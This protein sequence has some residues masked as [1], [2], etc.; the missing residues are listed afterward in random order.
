MPVK[1]GLL[2][3][4]LILGSH[5]AQA[6]QV[7]DTLQNYF[8]LEIYAGEA[9][10]VFI[11]HPRYHGHFRRDTCSTE[12]HGT[13]FLSINSGCWK[14]I[15]NNFS[16]R[17]WAIGGPAP[18]FLIGPTVTSE[19]DAINSAAFA[20]FLMG[21]DTIE[22]DSL[23]LIDRSI[24]LLT[25]NT[26]LG[27][28]DN[29]G[30]KRIN[31]PVTILTDTA[32][33]DDNSISVAD[34]TGFKKRHKIN[35]A[36]SIDFDSL[37]GFVAYT[38]SINLFLGGDTTIFLSG[39]RIQKQML[40]GDSVSLFFPMM[41]AR[42]TPVDSIRIENMVFNG[43]REKYNLNYDWRVSPTL[44]I[45]T[46][47]ATIISNCRFEQIPNEN[48]FLC[49]ATFEHCSGTDLN[50]SALHFSCSDFDRFTNVLY[51]NFTNTNQ[52]GNEIMQHSEAALTFSAKVQN[53]RVA[54]NRF[55]NIE[56]YGVGIF[57]NDD[58]TNEITDN[59]FDAP[60]GTIEFDPFYL[61]PETNL[62]YNNKNPDFTDLST[63]S[64]WVNLPKIT[65]PFACQGSSSATTPLTIGDT[66]LIELDSFS[67]RN[68]NANFVKAILPDYSEAYFTLANMEMAVAELSEFHQ[69]TFTDYSA[70]IKG[71]I[72][73][74]GHKD[75]RN[76]PGNW[77]YEPCGKTGNCTRLNLTFIVHSLPDSTE[78]IDC[79]LS[80]IEIIYDGE[81]ATWETPVLCQ[82]TP[83]TLDTFSLGKPFLRGD[84]TVAI[85]V[86]PLSSDIKIFPN[87]TRN[88]FQISLPAGTR[89]R[90]H[91]INTL[92][93]IVKEGMVENQPIFVGDLAKGLF[94]IGISFGNQI[95]F[96]NFAII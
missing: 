72:F 25:N 93:E 94:T 44:L 86:P 46:T 38:A 37:S 35:I 18:D 1:Y 61:Y 33:V 70:A 4:S 81:M 32:R 87:P 96:C 77:G 23:Y 27:T 26:Y 21:G 9:D 75:G 50:G 76:A 74:N 48:I 14:R 80:G 57:R 51:N 45:P 62:I 88:Y 28:C 85:S 82:K 56:E 16:P 12:N 17:Y 67:W 52:V 8:D 15:S 92:G 89:A 22:I 49:G 11:N 39:R 65:V 69:W 91:L 90:Y 42:T 40:P 53:L 34:N 58:Q 47:N 71:L 84:P 3:F 54:Y 55:E 7:T 43:N 29:C 79:P 95:Y 30:F 41:L 24:N 68:S 60:S 63:D 13:T 5:S 64:C 59:L 20:A 31:P 6:F 73:D 78:Q 19:T 83:I 36:Q 10:T 66:I 2:I